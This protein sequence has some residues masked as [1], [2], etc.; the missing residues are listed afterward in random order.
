M[1]GEQRG[2]KGNGRGRGGSAARTNRTA[3]D[4]EFINLELDAKQTKQYR[5]WRLSAEAVIDAWTELLEA[6]YRLN[7]KYDDYSSSIAAFLIPD[8]ENEN[9]GFILTGRGGN[10]YRAMSE[11]IFKHFEILHGDWRPAAE[12]SPLD[13]DAEF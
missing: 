7:T 10:A 4:S 13:R 12:H 1:T 11:V 2:Q 9:S 3:P 6:G 5:D 8:A